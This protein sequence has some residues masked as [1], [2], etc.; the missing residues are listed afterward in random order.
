VWTCGQDQK[1]IQ[2]W[3]H[4][5]EGTHNPHPS[6][7]FIYSS[8]SLIP[9][10][11][12]SIIIIITIIITNNIITN[13]QSLHHPSPIITTTTNYHHHHHQHQP[14]TSIKTYILNIFYLQDTKQDKTKAFSKDRSMFF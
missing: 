7:L 5:R 8:S 1:L 13:H 12:S 10:L 11:L 14:S 6:S 9:S 3:T 2:Q 4:A